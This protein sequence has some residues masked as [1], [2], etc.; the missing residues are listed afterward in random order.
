MAKHSQ[1][2]RGG[3]HSFGGDWTEKKLHVLASY[4]R[5]YTTALRRMPFKLEY[6]DAFAG[7]GHRTADTGSAGPLFPDLEESAQAWLDGSAR[8]ALKIDP[9][10]HRYI[11]IERSSGRS[12]ALE[13]LKKEFP[14]LAPTIEVHA[15][16]A[17]V[18]I[19]DLCAGDWRGRR[20]V[21]FLDPYGMQVE[22]ETVR[23][24]A[25]TQSIDMWLLFPLGIGVNRLTTTSGDIPPPWRARLTALLG[26][27]EWYDAIYR[28]E[29]APTLFGDEE[30]VVKASMEVIGGYF[31][32][33]LKKVFSGV[34]ENPLVL[35]NSKN[36]PLYLLCFAAGNPRG[37]PVALRIAKHLLGKGGL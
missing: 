27:D 35:R 12:Q 26:T 13:S 14:V 32:D 36:S 23:C 4:L 5:A 3:R 19:K 16:E 15:E 10:F 21:L 30:A 7:T 33:R 24:I 28:H 17:N 34:A 2:D 22:W 1:D 6:I 25:K 18:K 11:F 31:V 29:R 9:P 8:R 37:A 20:A